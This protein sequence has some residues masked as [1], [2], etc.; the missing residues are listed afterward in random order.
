MSGGADSMSCW[1]W[2][3]GLCLY[4]SMNLLTDTKLY[5]A[6]LSA[7]RSCF[8]LTD[9][10]VSVCNSIFMLKQQST[11]TADMLVIASE[12]VLDTHQDC[13]ASSAPVLCLVLGR[14][15]LLQEVG[16]ALA[17]RQRKADAIE[18]RHHLRGSSCVSCMGL[19]VLTQVSTTRNNRLV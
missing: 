5:L 1:R 7:L 9:E 15:D 14:S 18:E 19:T 10:F 8:L 11:L 6:S 12:C 2:Y 16:N 13:R 4:A 17:L 3:A